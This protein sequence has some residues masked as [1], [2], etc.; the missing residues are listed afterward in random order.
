S[1]EIFS[2]V[3]LDEEV[4]GVL[5][6]L[7]DEVDQASAIVRTSFEE[8]SVIMSIRPYIKSILFNLISNALK[9]RHP[10]RQPQVCISSQRQDS[11]VLITVADNGLGISPENQDKIFQ[12]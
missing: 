12:L 9:Y 5:S 6:N 1:M 4:A 11:G 8:V 2:P 7:Q 3:N 10:E